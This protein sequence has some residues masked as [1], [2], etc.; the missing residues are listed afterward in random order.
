MGHPGM[1]EEIAARARAAGSLQESLA[2]TKPSISSDE[3]AQLNDIISAAEAGGHAQ[4]PPLQSYGSGAGP[5]GGP[6]YGQAP[7]QPYGGGAGQPH[8]GGPGGG[9]GQ[10]YGAGP[11]HGQAPPQPYGAGPGYGQAPPQPYGAGPGGGPG[12]P[13]G[14]APFGGANL[15]IQ[16][17]QFGASAHQQPYGHPGHYQEAMTEQVR[18]LRAPGYS[19]DLSAWDDTLTT[20]MLVFGVLLVACFVAPWAVGGGK[21]MFAWSVFSVEGAPFVAK[22]VPI[23]LA[24]TGLISV[25]VGALRLSS[26]TRALAGTVIGLAPLAFQVATSKPIGWQLIVAVVATISLVTG[27]VVRSRHTDQILGRLLATIGVLAILALYLVPENDVMPIKGLI[28]QVSN[29]PGKAKLLPILGIGVGGISIGLVP[30]AATLLCLLVWLPSPSRAG[31]VVLAWVVLFWPFV[32]MIGALLLSENIVATLKSSLSVFIYLP[33]AGVAW[34]TL[35]SFG[36]AG[37]ISEQLS[38]NS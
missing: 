17:A 38:S 37:V 18:P 10:P 30:F 14:G 22:M 5:G 6:G 2:P 16:N 33:L 26:F 1:A 24:A 32:A 11:G 29:L 19:G 35:T 36:V 7:H 31:A 28:D 8:G 21:T 4:Q 27:L 12:Q 34:F 23:L 25:V 15:G 9:A 20:Q 3:Q 13:Y